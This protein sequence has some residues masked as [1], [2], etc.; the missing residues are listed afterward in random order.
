MTEYTILIAHARTYG[1]ARHPFAGPRS[2][3]HQSS[4]L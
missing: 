1:R 2:A 3:R 4:P